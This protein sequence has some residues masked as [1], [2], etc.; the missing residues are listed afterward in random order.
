[1]RFAIF[2]CSRRLRQGTTRDPVRGDDVTPGTPSPYAEVRLPFNEVPKGQITHEALTW[3]NSQNGW[4]TPNFI[5]AD[6]NATGES[7]L[8]T[9]QIKS[10]SP[11]T[12][13]AAGNVANASGHQQHPLASTDFL[14]DRAGHWQLDVG[15]E[16]LPQR[17]GQAPR[18]LF[19]FSSLPNP[20]APVDGGWWTQ[21]PLL[22]RNMPFLS[23][24]TR[25]RFGYRLTSCFN[26]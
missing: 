17:G 12:A 4:F 2:S 22:R 15:G 18:S 7:L 8:V 14:N 19:P 13:L 24:S 11:Q 10:G 21:L 20:R 6:G 5:D 1:M 16:V 25:G 26:R 9:A 3:D 23:G